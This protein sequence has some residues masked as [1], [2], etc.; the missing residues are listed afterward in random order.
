MA[1]Q[2]Y[3]LKRRTQFFQLPGHSPVSLIAIFLLA[4][5][6]KTAVSFRILSTVV[7]CLLACVLSC[8]L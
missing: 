7:H 3:S 4:C 6:I 5:Y 1:S 8:L 2:R